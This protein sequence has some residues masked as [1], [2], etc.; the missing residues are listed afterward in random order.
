ME[1]CEL[2]GKRILVSEKDSYR[3]VKIT[4][5]KVMEVSPSGNWTKIMDMNGR[6]YWRTTTEIA[7]IEVLVDLKAGKPIVEK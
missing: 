7:L 3:T 6:K 4:E 2:I 1:I 5:V